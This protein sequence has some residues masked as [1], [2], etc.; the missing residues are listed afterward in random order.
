MTLQQITQWFCYDVIVTCEVVTRYR[1]HEIEQC[2]EEPDL[3]PSLNITGKNFE[4]PTASVQ[5]IKQQLEKVT[6]S[7]V[8]WIRWSCEPTSRK[9][10]SYSF[11]KYKSKWLIH[12]ITVELIDI[13]LYKLHKMHQDILINV[14]GFTLNLL[15]SVFLVRRRYPG[16]MKLALTD[17]SSKW[18]LFNKVMLNLLSERPS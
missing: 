14:W 4:T 11:Q 7:I 15:N 12:K 13:I 8:N 9:T 16:N 18:E 2:R 1:L 10:G 5:H 3:S 6:Q 17:G